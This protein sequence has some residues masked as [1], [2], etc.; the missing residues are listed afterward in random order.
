MS[1][2]YNPGV[3]MLVWSFHGHLPNWTCEY[4]RTDLS[5]RFYWNATPGAVIVKDGAEHALTP[6]VF[7]VVPADTEFSTVA[8]RP[9]THFCI[10]FDVGSPFDTIAHKVFLFPADEFIVSS[11]KTMVAYQDI[12]GYNALSAFN[13]VAYS[14]LYRA[15]SKF[16]EGDFAPARRLD[17]RIARV[18]NVL[19][20]NVSS[21][22][23]NEALARMAGMS[24]SRFISLFT[25]EVGKAPQR[26]AR[27]RRVAKASRALVFGD[28]SIDLVAEEAGFVDR[29]HFSKIFKAVTGS[30][31]ASFRQRHKAQGHH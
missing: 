4:D 10:H 8:S 24:V 30:S 19:D 20:A 3:Q 12:P 6:E 1:I 15:L 13:L 16:Q 14:L 2:H 25:A 31:P 11:I 21:P 5:W 26:Y 7:C 22:I 18:V 28:K 27:D 9:I 29:Y 17:K 23:D